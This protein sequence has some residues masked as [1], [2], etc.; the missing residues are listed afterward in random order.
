MPHYHLKAAPCDGIPDDWDWP[1]TIEV[2]G[3]WQTIGPGYGIR[4]YDE[5]S[6]TGAGTACTLWLGCVARPGADW[7]PMFEIM[8]CKNAGEM[9]LWVEQ[10][11]SVPD[12]IRWVLGDGRGVLRRMKVV[13]RRL[14]RLMRKVE[15]G[16]RA[17]HART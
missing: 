8:T 17:V 13:A 10:V 15:K 4:G 2:A 11:F 5:R 3:A 12:M 16:K 9:E 7:L 6:V 1:A 14:R